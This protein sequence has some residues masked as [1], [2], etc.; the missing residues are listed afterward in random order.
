MTSIGGEY[1]AWGCRMIDVEVSVPTRRAH[2]E[3]YIATGKKA[4]SCVPGLFPVDTQSILLDETVVNGNLKKFWQ[5][6]VV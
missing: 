6:S 3:S 5:W 1:Y 2:T 4:K